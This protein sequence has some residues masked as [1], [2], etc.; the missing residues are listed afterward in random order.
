MASAKTTNH[1]WGQVILLQKPG[2]TYAKIEHQT[3]VKLSTAQ[4]LWELG[5]ITHNSPPGRPQKKT[6]S[7]CKSILTG[8]NT[9]RYDTVQ[10]IAKQQNTRA[11]TIR[12]IAAD[13]GIHQ[14]RAPMSCHDA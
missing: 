5:K 1:K 2:A 3:G 11:S 10:T 6:A 8:V 9:N 7:E 14:L 4:N 13:Q 12:R